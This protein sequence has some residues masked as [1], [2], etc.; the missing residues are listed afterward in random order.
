M[1]KAIG[2]STPPV[3][4]WK[5]RSTIICAQV[6]REGAGDREGQEQDGVGQQ[7]DAHREHPRQPAGQRDDD[8]L[9]DQVGGG[10]PAAVVDAGADRALDVGERGVDDL[11]VEHRHEGAERGAD[12]REPGLAA[13]TASASGWRGGRDRRRSRLHVGGGDMVVHRRPRRRTWRASCQPAVCGRR[14]LSARRD[15]RA[16]RARSPW[17]RSSAR[18]TCRGA[19]GRRGSWSSSTIF[20]GTR[21]T[22]L[23]KLPVALSGG[24][25]ANSRPLA[26]D[27]LSTWPF[28]VTPGKLSTASSTGWPAAHMGELR[29]LEVGDDI[30]RMQRHDRHQLR[31]GLHIL[32]DAQRARADRAVDRRGDRGVGEIELRLRRPRLRRGRAGPRPWR[33]AVVEHV[34]LALLRGGQGGAIAA[35]TRAV[36][37]WQHGLLRALHRAG[38]EV[39]LRSGSGSGS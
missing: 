17:C 9:G 16:R 21:C 12:H 25:S 30:D 13:E 19:A 39:I 37:C 3:K 38:R 31:A 18:P 27:R 4:P 29:L 34:D 35:A 26:G 1:V 6:V 28:S 22:I 14:R 32:A 24:S 10:D 36:C 11:D 15:C 7:I 20:T 2:I 23:V 5:A 33:A 8:D